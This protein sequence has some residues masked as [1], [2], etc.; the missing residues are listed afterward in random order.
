MQEARYIRI[1]NDELGESHFADL[2][3][4]LPPVDFAPPAPPLNFMRLFSAK[5]CGFL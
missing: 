2:V 3:V 4:V 1:Y 5:D